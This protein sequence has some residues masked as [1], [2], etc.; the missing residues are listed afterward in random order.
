MRK[1]GKYYI[2]SQKIEKLGK[3][4][5]DELDESEIFILRML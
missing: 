1:P 2:I 3:Q 4:Q 5:H